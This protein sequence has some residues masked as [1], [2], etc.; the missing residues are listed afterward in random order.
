MTYPKRNWYVVASSAE[1][2]SDPV[3]RTVCGE[4]LA[5]YRTAGDAR[6]ARFPFATA[7][8]G[9]EWLAAGDPT[10]SNELYGV[11]A[12]MPSACGI[13]AALANVS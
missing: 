11:A 8:S 2:G 13:G 7:E 9:C 4:P 3:G 12:A 10:S 6:P 1:I 5:L